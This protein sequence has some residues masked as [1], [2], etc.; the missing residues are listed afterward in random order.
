MSDVEILK[1]ARKLIKAPENWGKGPSLGERLC[2]ARAISVTVNWDQQRFYKARKYLDQALPRGVPRHVAAYNDR[3]ST[4]HA[5]ILALFDRAIAKA[6][7]Q[8][9]RKD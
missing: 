4:T 9:T 3:P 8:S 1:A 5:D 7:E 2:A 6:T